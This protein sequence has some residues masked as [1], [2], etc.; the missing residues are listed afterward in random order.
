MKNDNESDGRRNFLKLS[1]LAGGATIAGLGF[2]EAAPPKKVSGEKVKVLTADGR[3]LEVDA[4]L[5]THHAA[6]DAAMMNIR[7][8]VPGRKFVMVIDL[9]R[10]GN[11]RKC[12][13]GCQ[14]MHNVLPPVEWIKVHRMQDTPLTGPYWFPQPCYQCD[15]PPCTK[16]C[17]VDATFKRTDGIV[18]ID[19]TRCIGCK[20]CMAACPYSARSFNFGRPEQEQYD[21]T[22]ELKDPC[23]DTRASTVG[24]VAKCDFCP[25]HAAK[26]K[27]PSCVT[28]CPNGV[29]FYGDELEDTVTNGEETFRLKELLK[30]RAAYRQF[31]ELGTKP[32]VYYLPPVNRQFPFEEDTEKH[33]VKE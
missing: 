21:K 12:I 17:P 30:K 14:K 2:A 22:H 33:N 27:L 6:E 10:C 5:V 13:E 24:T 15:N 18:G 8:G 32:R 25:D 23:C 29:I 28:E 16:V 31:E 1:L 19:S 4:E 9:A 11:E 7:E 3:L 20:F 26:G